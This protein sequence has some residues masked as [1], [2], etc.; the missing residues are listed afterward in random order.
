MATNATLLGLMAQAKIP[1]ADLA[2]RSW[3]VVQTKIATLLEPGQLRLI[4]RAYALSITYQGNIDAARRRGNRVSQS[5]MKVFAGGHKEFH[6]AAEVLRLR[7]WSKGER[8]DLA[9]PKASET[10]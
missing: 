8:D 2:Q 1:L 5:D 4:A 7:A 3:D 9:N 10:D 6:D